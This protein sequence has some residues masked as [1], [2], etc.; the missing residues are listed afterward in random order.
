[1]RFRWQLHVTEYATKVED[2]KLIAFGKFTVK[3]VSFL[4][5]KST[6]PV[7][8]FLFLVIFEH[9][10]GHKNTMDTN[11]MD[12]SLTIIPQC[13]HQGKF[14]HC[15][16]LDFLTQTNHS[17]IWNQWLFICGERCDV[18]FSSLY[19]YLRGRLIFILTFANWVWLFLFILITLL[20]G[21]T[22][23]LDRERGA[24]HV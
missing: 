16:N 14:Q 8:P 2:I 6:F 1:M 22:G 12:R 11:T 3:H 20:I 18:L 5:W 13:P 4:A 15:K 23:R 9:G 7:Q 24:L 21:L 17:R 19:C 10:Y